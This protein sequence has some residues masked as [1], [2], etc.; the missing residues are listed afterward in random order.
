MH[1]AKRLLPVPVL[2]LL[3]SFLAW[4]LIAYASDPASQDVTVPKT[5]GTTTFTWTGTIPPG[6]NPSSSCAGIPA[7]LTDLHTINLSVPDGL[8]QNFRVTAAFKIVWE[9]AG[10]DLI[11][12][13]ENDAMEFGTSD[14]GAPEEA[15][16][17]ENPPAGMIRVIGCPFAAPTGTPYT[18]TLTLT[19]QSAASVSAPPNTDAKGLEFSASVLA[20]IQRDESE[21]LVEIAPDGVVYTCG[22]TGTSQAA[23]YAQVSFDGGDQF[24]LMGAAPRGQFSQGGGGDCALAIAN[25]KNA[26]GN[27]N[28]AY[29]GLSGLVNFTTSTS[30]DNGQTMMSSPTSQSIPGVDRQWQTFSDGNNVFLNYNALQP[31]VVTVQKSTDGGLSFGLRQSVSPNPSFPGP[32]RSMPAALNPSGN[33]MPVV[34]YPWTAGTAVNMAVSLDNGTTWNNCLAV[35]AEGDPSQSFPTADH[36]VEGNLYIGYTDSANWGSYV[37]YAPNAELMNCNG[38]TAAGFDATMGFTEPVQTNR[39]E[40][41]TTIFPWLV[42]GGAKGRVAQVYIGSKTPGSPGD[43]SLNHTWHVYVTQSLN[44]DTAARSFA[45]VQAS[46]HPMYY[47]QICLDGLGCTVN[48]GDRSMADFFAIDLN[49]KT[50]ELV[51]VFNFNNKRPRAEVGQVALPMVIRQIAGPSNLGGMVDNAGRKVLRDSAV[52]PEGDALAQFS[53]LYVTP[54]TFNVPPADITNVSVGPALDF[55]TGEPLAA[56]GFTVTMQ[57]KQLDTPSLQAALLGIPAQSLVWIFRY[58]G[59]FKQSAVSARWNPA[60]GF[61]YG[62]NDYEGT[63]TECGGPATPAEVG[64]GGCVYYRGG[65]PVQGKVDQA[66]GTIQMTVPMALIKALDNADGGRGEYPVERAA[67]AGDRMFAAAVYSQANPTSAVQNTQGFLIPLD[68]S[69]AM[70]FLIPG[71][72]VVVPPTP[73]PVTPPGTIGDA[74]VV[75]GTTSNGRFGG[76]LGLV[77]LPLG[78]A[79]LRRHR[80]L[81]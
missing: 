28:L 32:M 75:A 21:P 67:Q 64:Q 38:G 29:S 61:S 10:N 50:G 44:M 77:L 20:D 9:D 13:V 43:L 46:S 36:D 6:A 72:A 59:G 51:I 31:R 73:G 57:V 71:K 16:A 48:M 74:P 58:Q 56:G 41:T 60:Q 4:I 81:H 54:S 79:A 68:N 15:V 3:F 78:L 18:G 30:D 1:L 17:T 52:D 45:Q 7:Q 47:D 62:F 49:P 66:T 34:Y 39:G 76:A 19:V 80:K 42:A 24:H 27:Y 26:K 65:T 8:Y 37:A 5:A 25:E 55:A 33:G 22:P 2:A 70:D 11:L 23:E 53:N 12:T 14:G 35:T 63:E 69:P 40:V